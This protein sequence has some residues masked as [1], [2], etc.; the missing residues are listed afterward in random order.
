MDE[1]TRGENATK[2]VHL[3]MKENREQW[4][5]GRTRTAQIQETLVG[6]AER[7]QSG[8]IG[9]TAEVAEYLADGLLALVKSQRLERIIFKQA[10]QLFQKFWPKGAEAN[11][12]RRLIR[13]RMDGLARMEVLPFEILFDAFEKFDQDDPMFSDLTFRVEG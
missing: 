4:E 5:K 12:V 11:E 8:H 3:G 2:I 13:L 10:F 6:L 7:M 1:R 9:P